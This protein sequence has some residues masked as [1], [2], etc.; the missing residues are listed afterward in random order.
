[1]RKFLKQFDIKVEVPTLGKKATRTC[2]VSFRHIVT[3]FGYEVAVLR[4]KRLDERKVK[5][6]SNERI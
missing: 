5:E 6:L 4:L 3:I 2:L 1:M